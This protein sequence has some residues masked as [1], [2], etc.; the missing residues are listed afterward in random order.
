MQ[1]DRLPNE[2]ELAYHKRLIDGKLVDKT[3]ADCDYSELSQYVYGKEYASDVARRMMYGSKKTLDL[4]EEYQSS[5]LGIDTLAEI[6]HK[7]IELQK[8]R[9]KF[10]DYRNAFNKVVRDRAREEELNEIIRSAIDS[11]NLKKLSYEEPE[12][13]DTL[14]NDLV[15]S[16][17][18]IHYG[19]VVDNYWCKYN[20]DICRQMFEKY[21]AEVI[22]IGKLHHSENC[23]VM[24][25]GDTISGS[26]H[27]SITV[28]NKEN[29]IEQVTG[30][31]ELIATFLAELSRHFTYVKFISV[32]G[33][34]S[35]MNPNKDE[36]L[37]SER[38]DDLV[39]WYIDARLQNFDNVEVMFDTRI[40]PT[41][42]MVDIRGKTYLAIHG[43]FDP[44]EK[45]IQSLQ[46]MVGKQLCAIFS[47][48]K[49][50]ND[51]G[52]VQ[53]VK[54]VM[55]GSFLGMD[56]FCVQKRIYGK[57]EQM[58]CVCTEDGI[59]CYYDIAL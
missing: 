7:R 34:H 3:L 6:E 4:V 22:R 41:M 43:D 28:T 14:N 56:D 2:N 42:S 36:S 21:L 24:C 15:V 9:Q 13:F 31:S 20:S 50:H 30:V 33:N 55:S 1:L 54:T 49:H 18:D 44:S 29:V 8:E 38:L 57:P 27:Y 59:Q 48:H 5:G 12:V 32:S 35:R 58:V 51:I 53:G 10:F 26:I 37:A 16:L 52:T 23:Y 47:G 17:N 19:A 46:A 25:N 40:D 45:S 39:G 11:G